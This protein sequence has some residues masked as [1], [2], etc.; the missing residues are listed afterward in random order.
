MAQVPVR[1]PRPARQRIG[2]KTK[3]PHTIWVSCM[4]FT[5]PYVLNITIRFIP[6]RRLI[7]LHDTRYPPG[8]GHLP[9]TS[10]T[11][12]ASQVT[13]Q[14]ALAMG[15][16]S[17]LHPCISFGDKMLEDC[18]HSA[19]AGPYS[20]E[21]YPREAYP[22][23]PLHFNISFILPLYATVQFNIETNVIFGQ[24]QQSLQRT[25]S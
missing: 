10:W 6:R 22:V 9:N 1:T 12:L 16:A 25:G 4:P 11:S 21:P 2:W 8:L 19:Q 7:Y 15:V 20:C 24:P 5:L 17:A 23:A 3:I 14:G 13:H 18:S